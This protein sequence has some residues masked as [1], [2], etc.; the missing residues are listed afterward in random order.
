MKFTAIP[1]MPMLSGSPKQV[2]WGEEIRKS[3]MAGVNRDIKLALPYGEWDGETVDDESSVA[4]LV[5]VRDGIVKKYTAAKWWIENRG[6]V[7]LNNH[8][9]M[10]SQ[11]SFLNIK[12]LADIA[13]ELKEKAPEADFFE[14]V[15]KYIISRKC[16]G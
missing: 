3:F 2:A 8:N 13:S 6:E 11:F 5:T 7:R 15:D 1:E 10:Y 4:L 12:T 9:S 16:N 14:M